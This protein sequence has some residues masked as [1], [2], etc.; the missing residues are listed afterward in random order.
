MQPPSNLYRFTKFKNEIMI[1]IAE[2]F[3]ISD[4]KF[5]FSDNYK[6]KQKNIVEIENE[7]KLIK[8]TC[9]YNKDYH[10]STFISLKSF[11]INTESQI[12]I[13]L[14]SKCKFSCAACNRVFND[15]KQSKCCSMQGLIFIQ[16]A[17]INKIYI[18]RISEID[19]FLNL[20]RQEFI[21]LHFPDLL[22]NIMMR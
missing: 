7:N 18:P 21:D 11:D 13:P 17:E 1:K 15:N 12:A 14:Y 19:Y 6:I 20:S 22:D 16:E 3:K 2:P 9:H 8:K 10:S 4:N 5:A